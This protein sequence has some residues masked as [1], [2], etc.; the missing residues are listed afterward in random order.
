M[1]AG[2]PALG[3]P[4]H[5]VAHLRAQRLARSVKPFLAR[6]GSR[7][8]RCVACRLPASHCLCGHHIGM[9]TRPGVCLIMGDIEAIKPSNT[10]WL[11]ADV[12]ADTSAFG[13]AR[14]TVD[15]ALLSLLNHPQWEAVLVFPGEYVSPERVTRTLPST[16]GKR[17]LFVLL[18]GTWSEARKM[19]HKSPYLDHLPVISLHPDRLSNYR[20]RRSKRDDHLC[21]AEVASLCLSMADEP[22]A[23]QRLD[24]HLDVYTLHYLQAK[25]Q[26]LPDPQHP[27]YQRWLALTTPLQQPGELVCA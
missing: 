6:G 9:N 2:E 12:V 4:P 23:A 20:L 25:Q 5:A 19:F 26:R 14:T 7:V 13:W 1:H 18:D 10:G 24:A 21:T 16:P 27:A 15:P 3:P 22:L 17:P 8:E 11:V